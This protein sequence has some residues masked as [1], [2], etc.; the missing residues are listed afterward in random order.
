MERQK[1]EKE[2]QKEKRELE[3]KLKQLQQA[4]DPNNPSSQQPSNQTIESATGGAMDEEIK[5]SGSPSSSKKKKSEQEIKSTPK[6]KKNNKSDSNLNSAISS[7]TQTGDKSSQKKNST[8][9]KAKVKIEKNIF[10]PGSKDIPYEEPVKDTKMDEEVKPVVESILEPAKL[11]DKKIMNS[12]D[13]KR[14]TGDPTYNGV[15]TKNIPAPIEA[16]LL[17]GE[18][19]TFSPIKNSQ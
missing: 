17:Q 12:E 15:P 13:W 4:N 5:Q 2:K 1:I 8:A 9:K 7:Q 14:I 3:K 11:D 6:S 10:K 16:E 19:L 18:R